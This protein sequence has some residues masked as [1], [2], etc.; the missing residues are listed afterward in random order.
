MIIKNGI[1]FREDKAFIKEDLC[2]ESGRIVES[3]NQVADTTEID[4]SGL[5]VLPGLVDIHS[6]GAVGHDFSDNNIE[7]L[8]EILQYE[9]S[10]GITTYCPTSMTLKKEKI[11]RI[12]CMMEN[13]QDQKGLSH[14]AGINMEGPF[15]DA[16]KKGAHLQEYILPPDIGFFRECNQLCKNMIRLVTLAP[17][18]E[19]AM[20]FIRELKN[21]VTISLGH[22]AADYDTAKQAFEAGACHVTH[23]FNAMNP[24]EHRAPGLIAAA[25]E[26][27]TCVA[28]LIC[29]GIHVHES[30]VR[31]AFKLFP[32]RIALISDS[33]KATGM[34][35]GTYDLGG[36]Q[37]H[38]NGKLATL[39]DGT[40]A[41]SA[42]N[43]YD[44]MCNAVAFG[45]PLEEAVAAASMVPAKSIGIFDEVGSLTPGKRADVILADKN[46][47]L[48]K[49]I[50]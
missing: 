17:N 36:Q 13:W 31:T 11:C 47:K 42:T 26:N 15:L 2:I 29:D 21:E 16:A 9:Y 5:Y 41:G 28:E 8:H 4:A 19:G 10:H 1:V 33:M 3:I 45:I 18:M 37:V 43:L 38:V 32:G 22:S 23:L 39:S 46:L 34:A 48:I 12:F 44:G 7:D 14:V 50:S 24:L 20:E 27:E 6:H 35:D 25:A 30:M 40:I 49:V